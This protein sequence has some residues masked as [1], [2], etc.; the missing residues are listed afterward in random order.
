LGKTVIVE[1]GEIE[2]NW[3]LKLCEQKMDREELIAEFSELLTIPEFEKIITH[4]IEEL[5]LLLSDEI[6]LYKNVKHTFE[7][8][9]KGNMVVCED[10]GIERGPTYRFELNRTEAGE[11]IPARIDPPLPPYRDRFD[12]IP[13]EVIQYISRFTPNPLKIEKIRE[14]A[15][16]SLKE[17]IFEFSFTRYSHHH[18]LGTICEI[19]KRTIPELSKPDKRSNIGI[20]NAYTKNSEDGN[21]REFV[22]YMEKFPIFKDHQF[23]EF[24]QKWKPLFD[25][26]M[27][28]GTNE[29]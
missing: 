1:T 29:G 5:K 27:I 25:N 26:G 10:N 14:Y 23:S 21:Y 20:D 18:A 6:T 19:K 17:R 13:H 15:P 24:F 9:A 3:L 4:K 11:W 8:T 16:P 28:L 7:K 12:V 22:F 2:K